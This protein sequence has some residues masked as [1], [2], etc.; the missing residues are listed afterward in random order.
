M[1]KRSFIDCKF[2][3]RHDSSGNVIDLISFAMVNAYGQCFY[4]V[5][6]QFDWSLASPGLREV[7]MP[8]LFVHDRRGPFIFLE[9]K[10][11]TFIRDE[12]LKFMRLDQNNPLELWS[13]FG[14]YDYR[15]LIG[16]FDTWLELPAPIPQICLDLYQRSVQLSIPRSSLPR[17]T[18]LQHNALN[19]A[20]WHCDIALYLDQ[21]GR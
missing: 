11:R 3:E 19:D 13:W 14:T 4:A 7:V 1:R 21:F 5:S 10:P 12:L 20:L 18:T 15:V 8:R 6:S 17:Q 2:H 9:P 16:L